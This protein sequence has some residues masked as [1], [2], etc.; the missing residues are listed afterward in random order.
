MLQ[1]GLAK[2]SLSNP[3]HQLNGTYT[4]RQS[5]RGL[6]LLSVL[7]N[8]GVNL[9]ENECDTIKNLV[10]NQI[11]PEDISKQVVDCERIGKDIYDKMVK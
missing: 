2:D 9:E 4:D 11:F 1:Q 6:S 7:D 10:T 5:K 8:H 3:K